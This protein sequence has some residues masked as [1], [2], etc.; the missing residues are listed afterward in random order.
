MSKALIEMFFPSTIELIRRYSPLCGRVILDEVIFPDSIAKLC[1][2]IHVNFRRLSDFYNNRDNNNDDNDNSNVDVGVDIFQLRLPFLFLAACVGIFIGLHG[3]FQFATLYI[4]N[5]DTNGDQQQDQDKVNK[6]KSTAIIMTTTKKKKK[7]NTTNSNSNSMMH[8]YLSLA[9]GAFGIMNISAVCIHCLW[10]APTGNSETTPSSMNTTISTYP[11][12]Y[13]FCWVCDAYMTGFSSICLFFSCLEY[14]LLRTARIKLSSSATT[15]TAAATATIMIA[16]KH[17]RY[18]LLLFRWW[19]LC[20]SLGIVCVLCCY[21]FN[22]NTNANITTTLPLEL[23]YL[24]PMIIVSIPILFIM[25]LDSNK[26]I[27][28]TTPIPITTKGPPS[29]Y[30]SSHSHSYP[31]SHL[32]WIG[33]GTVLACIG[34]IFD[35]YFC[36]WFHDV[37]Y[38][39]LTVSTLVFWSCDLIFWGIYVKF[40]TATTTTT[41]NDNT[42]TTTTTRYLRMKMN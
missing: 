40:I 35:Q 3:C 25:I 17:T 32:L 18:S 7:H 10:D 21:F 29:S 13:P 8:I 36:L 34:I 15:A 22:T 24:L 27:Q 19:I 4:Q 38:D 33:S 31:Y 6:R 9:F 16:G 1:P 30:S 23:W 11:T 28:R 26:I 12:L 39:L 37:L 42:A 41:T 20:Q 2:E 14:I 5:N